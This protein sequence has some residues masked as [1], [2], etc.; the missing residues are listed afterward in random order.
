[1]RNFWSNAQF[2]I[3][4]SA[5]LITGALVTWLLKPKNPALSHRE[6]AARI[7]GEYAA[8]HLK[9]K[10]ILV[11]S[12]PFVQTEGRPPEIYQHHEAALRGLRH[13]FGSAVQLQVV[14]PKLKPGVLE[15]PGAFPL[16]PSSRTPLSFLVDD[17]AFDELIRT[18]SECELAIS[19]IG[20]PLNVRTLH[21]WQKPGLPVFALLLPDWRMIGAFAEI[22][23]AF[24]A[25]K[26]MGAVVEKPGA[27]T[28][29][30]SSNPYSLFDQLFFLVTSNNFAEL[31]RA[32]PAIFGL[33][34]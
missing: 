9:P 8:K 7:L 2:A 22:N 33:S 31:A 34:P 15:N 17:R 30:L 1:M 16:D 25:G 29:N 21:C 28:A 20:L 4:F 14:F 12:N 3:L 13:A 23:Q 19:L 27:A 26:L 6:A 10:S 5:L 18:H 24:S 32:H 11:I